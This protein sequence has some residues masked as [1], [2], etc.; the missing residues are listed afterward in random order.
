[1][2]QER[3]G[4]VLLMTGFW[5]VSPCALGVPGAAGVPV[6]PGLRPSGVPVATGLPAAPFVGDGPGVD[7]SPAFSGDGT[8]PIAAEVGGTAAGVCA[9]P[10]G[11]GVGVFVGV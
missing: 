8:L 1:M 10:P 5:K 4:E 2:E 7:V 9:V 6:A 11:V 3:V